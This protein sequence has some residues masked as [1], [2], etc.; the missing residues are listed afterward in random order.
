[1]DYYQRLHNNYYEIGPL[2]V[3]L[4]PHP[5]YISAWNL[6]P[7]IAGLKEFV[8]RCIEAFLPA[9]GIVKP[10]VALFE[11]YGSEG[12]KILESAITALREAGIV[13][14][15]DAKRGDIGSTMQAYAH[16]WFNSAVSPLAS[17]AVTVSP[18]L[19]SESLN[20]MGQAIKQFNTGIFA[21]TAT[22]NPDAQL[23]QDAQTQQGISV[24]QSVVNWATKV[25]DDLPHPAVG[26]V[27]GAT[28]EHNLDLHDFQGP[29]LIPGMGVQGGTSD[30]LK[31][32]FKEQIG[33]QLLI[34]TMSRSLLTSGPSVSVLTSTIVGY[35]RELGNFLL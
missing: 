9:A 4:D 10:Q 22:S 3:G 16:S 17:D 8:A 27:V 34:P 7:D 29:I 15:A 33:K 18:Y 5:H 23:F 26:I 1:M 11:M 30:S 21:L 25:N 20:V 35:N 31:K 6:E 32:N 24:A 14:I 13:V 12:F 2:C 19:G 28:R